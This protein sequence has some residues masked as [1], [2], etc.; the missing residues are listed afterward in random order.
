[1]EVQ[2]NVVNPV[3]WWTSFLSDGLE[4]FDQRGQSGV[5]SQDSHLLQ[6]LQSVNDFVPLPHSSYSE[7]GSWVSLQVIFIYLALIK[8]LFFQYFQFRTNI[9]RLK[10]WNLMKKN[11]LFHQGAWSDSSLVRGH[12]LV[13]I[14]QMLSFKII[15]VEYSYPLSVF[16]VFLVDCLWDELRL[17][18]MIKSCAAFFMCCRLVIF[19]WNTNIKFKNY[20]K[21]N[22]KKRII[23][24]MLRW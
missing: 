8:K 2:L 6:L 16:I 4:C 21:D 24:I 11:L 3:Q 15:F 14:I 9:F 20:Y 12:A 19:P 22:I 23:D 17:V 1:M 18:L 13:T 10:C 5:I 7:E